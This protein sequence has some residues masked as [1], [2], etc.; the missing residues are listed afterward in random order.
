MDK[1]NPY[2]HSI[3]RRSK[4]SR[5]KAENAPKKI[6]K[7]A[8]RS[9]ANKMLQSMP[10]TYSRD[11]SNS[12]RD[13]RS[14]SVPRKRDRARK[15]K[16]YNFAVVKAG[17]LNAPHYQTEPYHASQ[18][19]PNPQPVDLTD[20]PIVPMTKKNLY[21][22]AQRTAPIVR[23]RHH[24]CTWKNDI[25]SVKNASRHEAEAHRMAR[26]LNSKGKY[27]DYSGL[28]AQYLDDYLKGSW[29]VW[30]DYEWGDDKFTT[31][32][33][34]S[35]SWLN[36][37]CD[38]CVWTRYGWMS[39]EDDQDWYEGVG[40]KTPEHSDTE[41][42]TGRFE[43]LFDQGSQLVDVA[44]QK[45]NFSVQKEIAELGWVDDVT[46]AEEMSDMDWDA[47]GWFGLRDADWTTIAKAESES[48]FEMV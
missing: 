44:L 29:S 38:D 46:N 27:W 22:E 2:R 7:K 18:G 26:G 24:R 14:S 42:W 33:Y 15:Y 23:H 25:S 13:L 41:E 21:Q 45:T 43:T 39:S 4:I 19:W 35:E 28:D 37:R 30:D 48:S 17:Q 16:Y 47:A 31:W 40:T 36:C 8:N 9:K 6:S 12:Y 34:G 1:T 20:L 11:C 10:T 5:S 32:D 3:T